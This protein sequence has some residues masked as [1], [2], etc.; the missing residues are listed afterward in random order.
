MDQLTANSPDLDLTVGADIDLR[1]NL[2]RAILYRDD[3]DDL[4]SP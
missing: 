4:P 2:Q 1:E 3:P